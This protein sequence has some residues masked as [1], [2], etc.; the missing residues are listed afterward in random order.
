MHTDLLWGSLNKK[1]SLRDL[2][3]DGGNNYKGVVKR[4]RTGGRG[5]ESSAAGQGYMGD[6]REHGNKPSGSTKCVEFLD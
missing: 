1:D 2:D 5:L 6:C 3:S 4:S